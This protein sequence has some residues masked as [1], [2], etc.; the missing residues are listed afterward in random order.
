MDRLV[1]NEGIV[2]QRLREGTCVPKESIKTRS[3][4]Q[5]GSLVEVCAALFLSD[6]KVARRNCDGTLLLYS[7][8]QIM[9][10]ICRSRMTPLYFSAPPR[11][12]TLLHSRIR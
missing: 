3:K 6:Q 1:S 12:N 8:L 5:D 2:G 10:I 7:T 4:Y 11:Q 9:S